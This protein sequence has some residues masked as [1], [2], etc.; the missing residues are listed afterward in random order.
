MPSKYKVRKCALAGFSFSWSRNKHPKDSVQSSAYKSITKSKQ[1][2]PPPLT[3]R[4]SSRTRGAQDTG[5]NE[6]VGEPAW[7]P[8]QYWS[9]KGAT[10]FFSRILINHFSL[11]LAKRTTGLAT[12][13]NSTV[14]V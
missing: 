9:P 8:S 7:T 2:T 4:T 11:A 3:N 10:L 1:E 12:I 6:V 5:R 13:W 14:W